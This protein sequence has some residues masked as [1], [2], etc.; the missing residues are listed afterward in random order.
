MRDR[1][2]L[3]KTPEQDVGQPDMAGGDRMQLMRMVVHRQRAGNGGGDQVIHRSP[4]PGPPQPQSEDDKRKDWMTSRADM[5]A[6]LAG[7]PTPEEMGAG[8]GVDPAV[9]EA[10]Q[11]RY[12]WAS[13]MLATKLFDPEAIEE[14]EKL[15]YHE[16][17]VPEEIRERA[18]SKI[19]KELP[20]QFRGKAEGLLGQASASWSSPQKMEQLDRQ[21]MELTKHPYFGIGGKQPLDDVA[22]YREQMDG[23]RQQ[24]FDAYSDT[25]VQGAE[26]ESKIADIQVH[27]TQIQ[28]LVD[29]LAAAASI[30]FNELGNQAG[31]LIGNAIGNLFGNLCEDAFMNAVGERG[32]TLQQHFQQVL[33]DPA[34]VSDEVL[35]R[36]HSVVQSLGMLD[37]LQGMGSAVLDEAVKMAKNPVATAKKQLT[38]F[39]G[40]LFHN[41][42]S[43]KGVADH[44]DDAAGGTESGTTA[45]GVGQELLS[46]ASSKLI[47]TVL[48]G[49][50]YVGAR[51]K[52]VNASG[53]LWK[54][55]AALVNRSDAH[56][57]LRTAQE[58]YADIGTFGDIPPEGYSYR[59]LSKDLEE[60]VFQL[61]PP[62]QQKEPDPN[63]Q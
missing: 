48:D 22:G 25:E 5:H 33:A 21:L 42:P 2:L 10:M 28:F 63:A 9:Q 59:Y 14:I 60:Q 24:L 39:Q 50:A 44:V 35:D 17:E 3:S 7:V 31:D 43:D 41:G 56:H 32:K 16:I 61:R 30:G 23:Y 54:L 29:G 40:P 18:Q 51:A 20:A 55:G 58:S 46:G 1:K 57:Q 52:I 6:S 34:S 19:L 27:Q 11:R 15:A 49:C 47:G 38:P 12:R 62:T 53:S 45:L 37:M 26:R 13:D 8:N 36:L 4:L